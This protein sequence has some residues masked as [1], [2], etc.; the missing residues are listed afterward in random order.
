M[1]ADK[2]QLFEWRWQNIWLL[3]YWFLAPKSEQPNRRLRLLYGSHCNF[4]KIVGFGVLSFD[5]K[6]YVR[7]PFQKTITNSPLFMPNGFIN[8]KSAWCTAW[9][10]IKLK[11]MQ[12]ETEMADTQ[13][14][15]IWQK[16]KSLIIV[17]TLAIIVAENT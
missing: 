2:S 8:V 17:I 15:Q 6:S 10:T 9:A 4:N 14:Q 16:L 12:P 11:W 7:Q 1:N 3:D 5:D 13:K